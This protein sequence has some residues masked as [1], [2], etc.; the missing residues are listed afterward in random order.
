M[1]KQLF[2]LVL[3]VYLVSFGTIFSQ[4]SQYPKT[5]IDGTEY[6]IYTVQEGEGLFGIARKFEVSLDELKNINPGTGNGL[7][8]GQQMF[9]PTKKGTSNIA[10]QASSKTATIRQEYILHKVENKQTLFAI[11]K[12]YKVRQ[13]DIIKANPQISK[14]L[15]EGVTLRIPKTNSD[16]SNWV[17]EQNIEKAV[18]KVKNT[19]TKSEQKIHIVKEDETLYSI[20]RLYNVTVVDIVRLNPESSKN[21]PIGSELKIPSI[22]QDDTKKNNESVNSK[23]DVVV[24]KYAD[25]YALEKNGSNTKV[26]KIAFL[27]PFMLD[28]EKQD[29]SDKRF[30]DFY[31]GAL[32]AV[33]KA[34]LRGISCEI[35]TFD[36]G[37][38]E[39]KIKEVLANQELKDMDLIIGPAFSNQ[40]SPVADFAKENKVNTLIPFSSKVY[41]IE[42]NPYLFQFNP[43]VEAEFNFSASLLTTK[44]LNY[45][46]VF[47]ELPGISSSDEGR[48]WS[49]ALKKELGKK[50]KTFSKIELITSDNADFKSVLK[51]NEKNLVI[52]NTD[53]YA[54]MNPFIAPLRSCTDKYEIIL[55]EQYNWKNQ[56]EKMPSSVYVSP[57]MS[58]YN[59]KE[60]GEFNRLY[61]QLFKNDINTDSPRFDL[62]GYDLSTYFISIIHRYGNKFIDKIGNISITNGIQSQPR[63]ERISNESGFINQRL[64]LSEDKK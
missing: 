57:F 52:F 48:I 41:D 38:S 16:K 17:S 39:Q 51:K 55:F 31:S 14:G 53:K 25:N 30:I 24:K 8:A 32:I 33:H 35:F 49:E 18:K 13:E 28:E 47:A 1:K 20:S 42:N 50:H 43:G 44:Y 34:K 62:L 26:I 36:T 27:L 61:T 59:P 22:N 29:P 6:Y 15:T 63:F 40:I 64:Y 23:S 56:N 7:K 2:T 19:S 12:K 11:S 54:Y 46:I 58:K 45:N 9:V 10:N 21:L 37:K 60:L 3:A 4:N 5:K